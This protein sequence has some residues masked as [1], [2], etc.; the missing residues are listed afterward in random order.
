MRMAGVVDGPM[1]C[2]EL[3]VCLEEPISETEVGAA[4]RKL[5][6]GKAC[7]PDNI[8]GVFWQAVTETDTGLKMAD[9]LVQCMLERRR[10]AGGLAYSYGGFRE[11]EGL[12]ERL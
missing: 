3:L 11:Q 2:D 7:G 12:R 5:K 6:A 10:D 9:W 4:I 8:T 1:L